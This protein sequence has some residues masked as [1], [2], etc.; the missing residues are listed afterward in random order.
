MGYQRKKEGRVSVVSLIDD[1]RTVV[2]AADELLNDK[3]VANLSTK[4]YLNLPG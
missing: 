1:S 4:K 3:H 2:R